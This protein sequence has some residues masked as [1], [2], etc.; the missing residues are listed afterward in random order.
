MKRF[1]KGLF[2]KLGYEIEY[3]GRRAAT[4]AAPPPVAKH[5]REWT[6]GEFYWVLRCHWRDVELYAMPNP[7]VPE[8]VPIRV[9]ETSSPLIADCR[10]PM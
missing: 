8:V 9:T 6:A 2:R 5:V 7:Y 1:I 4:P 10:R 3:V